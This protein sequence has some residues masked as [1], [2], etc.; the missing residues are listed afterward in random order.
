MAF[1]RTPNHNF[2]LPPDGAGESAT[3]SSP[4]GESIRQMIQQL[5]SLVTTPKNVTISTQ[6]PSGV[7]ADGDEWVVYQ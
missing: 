6:P 2:P 7:P 4:W 5:D 1:P 3:P